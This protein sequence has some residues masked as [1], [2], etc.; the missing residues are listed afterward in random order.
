MAW[1]YH[2][3]EEQGSASARLT[4][5]NQHIT[6]VRAEIGP[7]LGIAGRSRQ[8]D[9]LNNYLTTLYARQKELSASA[10]AASGGLFTR[11]RPI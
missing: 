1:T 11:G 6:E 8:N 3:F 2:D 10:A 9:V 4:R 5:L 7:N